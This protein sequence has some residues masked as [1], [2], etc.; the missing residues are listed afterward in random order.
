MNL[1]TWLKDFLAGL[2]DASVQVYDDLV[3]QVSFHFFKEKTEIFYEVVEH[4]V[5]KFSLKSG[6]YIIE[7]SVF[8]YENI[9]VGVHRNA[10]IFVHR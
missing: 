6:R 2:E 10:Y 1:F 9:V 8:L 3:Y 7:K 4:Q 5:D